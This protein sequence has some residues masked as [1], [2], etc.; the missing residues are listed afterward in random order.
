M[1]RLVSLI[2]CAMLLL[3]ASATA[4]AEV[5]ATPVLQPAL[6]GAS[7]AT[8]Y[9][10]PGATV[11][12][13]YN[14]ELVTSAILT[15]KGSTS[16]YLSGRGIEVSAGD[17]LSA[18]Q[19]ELGKEESG[20]DTISIASRAQSAAPIIRPVTTGTETIEIEGVS[21]AQIKLQLNGRQVATGTVGL[22]GLASFTI[23]QGALNVG[24]V[25]TATQVEPGKDE[26]APH[27]ITVTQGF[28]ETSA[29]P[30][31]QPATEGDSAVIVSGVP[32]ASITLRLNGTAVNSA[33]VGSGGEAVFSLPGGATLAAGDIL[34]ATQTEPNKNPSRQV[35]YT[36]PA[37]DNVTAPPSIHLTRAGDQAVYVSGIA[38][39]TIILSVNGNMFGRQVVSTDNVATFDFT[40]TTLEE[41]D[42]LSATQTEPN[43]Y[44]SEPHEVVVQSQIIVEVS[45]LPEPE[46]IY[47][48]N[49]T[50]TLRGKPGATIIITIEDTIVI[51]SL[52][53]AEGIGEFSLSDHGVEQLLYG[54]KLTLTQVEVGKE[55]SPTRVL[56]VG[57]DTINFLGEYQG[58]KTKTFTWNLEEPEAYPTAYI[59]G[60]NVK[61][62]AGPSTGA[63]VEATAS[64]PDTVLLVATG[65][66]ENRGW[67]KVI[68]GDVVYYVEGQYISE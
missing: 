47:P 19:K 35:N 37:L 11:F 5:S 51:S 49:S 57:T 10:V 2:L 48:G 45:S 26:S 22:S 17:V 56:I 25:L 24:D 36:V 41:G 34:S 46:T 8:V 55:P 6:E 28:T 39:A 42:V 68:Y 15:A 65:Q 53:P 3:A 40:S 63:A 30:T 58:T 43:K 31:I 16:F 66:G 14:G 29:Q 12:L 32:G 4:F 60:Q 9:G 52:M 33:N 18:T 7:K 67:Y 20:A 1:K 13:Y 21:G 50:I 23:R 54:M 38:G 64:E 62:R 61:L 59:V 27:S 44:Q